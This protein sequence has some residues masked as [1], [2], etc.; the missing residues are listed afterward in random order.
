MEDNDR[1]WLT[2]GSP[3]AMLFNHGYLSVGR[4]KSDAS[5]ASAL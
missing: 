5:T 3:L 4:D 1:D 2:W